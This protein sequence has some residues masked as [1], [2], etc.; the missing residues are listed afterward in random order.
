MVAPFVI[1]LSSLLSLTTLSDRSANAPDSF[2][3][4]LSFFRLTYFLGV[5][6]MDVGIMQHVV[7]YDQC[8]L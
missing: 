3:L 4:F 7:D 2:F 5:Y 8:A 1:F 6:I